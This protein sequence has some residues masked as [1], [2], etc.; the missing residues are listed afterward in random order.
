MYWVWEWC[1]GLRLDL[2]FQRQVASF[3]CLPR[4]QVC[5]AASLYDRVLSESHTIGHGG[6]LQRMS[7]DM[8]ICAQP[9]YCVFHIKGIVGLMLILA[10]EGNCLLVSTYESISL[11][12][13]ERVVSVFL[14][15]LPYNRFSSLTI[16][17][18]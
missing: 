7:Q 11:W 17:V 5:V 1:H 4:E 2:Y 15:I 13:L 18:L 10:C 12:L 8:Y 6:P 16:F 3:I 14:S 9:F